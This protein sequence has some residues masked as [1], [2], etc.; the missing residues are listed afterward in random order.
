MIGLGSPLGC[1]KQLLWEGTAVVG[2]SQFPRPDGHFLFPR[3]PK[4]TLRA[5][6][7]DMGASSSSEM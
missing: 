2:D 5:N 4:R 7:D 1:I 3:D 6:K